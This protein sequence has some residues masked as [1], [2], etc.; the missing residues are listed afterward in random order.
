MTQD[1]LLPEWTRIGQASGLDPLGMARPT[2]TIYQS[3]LP[4]ISTI[5]NRLR[6]YSFLPWVLD[7]YANRFHIPDPEEFFKFQRRCEALFALAGVSN[8][9]DNGLSGANWASALVNT[10]GET[11]NFGATAENTDGTG[12]LKN[13]GGALGAIY[14]P[15]LR[16]MGLVGSSQN[17]AL[18]VVTSRGE[19]L[20]QSL[21]KTLSD[22]L[23]NF[24]DCVEV[25]SVTRSELEA[26]S[27]LRPSD[28]AADTPEQESLANLLLGQMEN[29]LA[30]DLA[31]RK[32]MLRILDWCRDHNRFPS[33]DDLRW[34]WF[35][36]GWTSQ[37]PNEESMDPWCVYQ[38]ND[39]L[40]LAYEALLKRA[41]EVISAC[42]DR[43]CRP[44]QLS[45]LVFET[46]G[47][48]ILSSDF[49]LNTPAPSQLKTASEAI[50]RNGDPLTAISDEALH[51]AVLIIQT[52]TEWT[53]INADK[54]E[55]LFPNTP[56]F[57]SILS[58]LNFIMGLAHQNTRHVL[59]HILKERV[60]KRH[61]WVASRKFR[62]QSAY[63]FLLEPD[64]GQL[65]YRGNF[66]VTPNNPRLV[67]AIQF[68]QDA[69]L[70]EEEIGL[71]ELGRKALEAA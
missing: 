19:N 62:G 45:E 32:T 71:S 54:L 2:E 36:I 58:E 69:C 9:Y 44:G 52:I 43:S 23:E 40:R 60:I 5:T 53:H 65:R 41:L 10:S 21:R 14:G 17:H 42:P 16:E 13:R 27:V 12:Y 50:T 24:A 55:T 25:G 57:Q 31:R 6:Y 33:A 37:K 61:L 28:I 47:N 18:A 29:P 66:I 63:T 64:E 68:L 1:A 4:G 49:W 34:D 7:I 51:S 35:E 11:I 38:A 3:L 26:L 48:E 39:L 59:E 15:Q 67:Q 8:M 46:L 22:T 70:L 56:Q 30:E 20:A